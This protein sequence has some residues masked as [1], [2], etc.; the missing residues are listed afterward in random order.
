MKREN[1]LAHRGYWSC[2]EDQNSKESLITALKFGYGIETDLRDFNG[3]IVISH[4][5]PSATGFMSF[6]EVCEEINELP[7]LGR[8]ALNI[9][10][11]GLAG[12][13]QNL[14]KK[15][16]RVARRCFVFDMS[17]PDSISYLKHGFRL[18]SRTSEFEG[19]IAFKS[20]ASGI[21]VDNFT[22]EFDQ[23]VSSLNILETNQRAAIVSAE[24]HGRYHEKLW[25]KIKEA[26]LQMFPNFEIC[27]DYPDLAA[28]YFGV[29]KND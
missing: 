26:N 24:L 9:K 8:I 3:D 7:S 16:P 23:L 10:S 5:P 27:T 29:C 20:E 28:E 19:E 25:Q 11:D 6:N 14:L 13:I 2:V 12:T 4:D 22:G 21:W 1:I 15:Y 17:I 18:Y